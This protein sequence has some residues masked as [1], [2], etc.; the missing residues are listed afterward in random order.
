M[1]FGGDLATSREL[2]RQRVLAEFGTFALRH[3]AAPDLFGEA[4]RQIAHATQLGHV[5]IA[6]HEAGQDSFVAVAS[7]GVKSPRGESLR[8]AGAPNSA[9]ERVRRTGHSVLI[10]DTRQSGEAEPSDIARQ[11]GLGSV[12]TL[13][14]LQG[15][16]VTGV[17]EIG[18]TEPRSLDAADV[19]LVEAMAYMLGAALAR[20]EAEAERDTLL[21]VLR[22][23]E[24]RYRFMA[25]SIPHIVWTAD[26]KGRIDFCNSRWT[27]Y[28]GLPLEN[29]IGDNW[30]DAIHPEDREITVAGWRV[31][32]A[33]GTEFH[34]EHRIRRAGGDWRWMVSRA[35]PLRNEAGHV[36]RWFGTSTDIDIERQARQALLDARDAAE[37]ANRAKSR[38]LAAASHDLR[39]PLNAITL[40]VAVLRSRIEDDDMLELIDRIE[41]SLGAM[42]ELFEALLD[43]SKLESG[44]VQLNVRPVALG[45]VLE[46]IEQDFRPVAEA[47]GLRFRV[48]PTGLWIATD[49]T[50]LER[51]LRNLVSN[52]IRYTE[53]G[54][55]LV[56]ARARGD[57]VRVEVV[58][59][60]PG[61]P[62]EHQEEIFDE[63]R[64]LRNEA[65]ERGSGHG[66]GLA[67][68]KRASGLLRHPVELKSR[69]G[70]GSRFI[71]EIP[72]AAPETA[73]QENSP[74]LGTTVPSVRHLVLVIEDDSL[75]LTATRLLLEQYGS[76]VL[77]ARTAEEA[78]TIVR[79]GAMPSAVVADF[80]LPGGVDG[81]EA[82]RM[83]RDALGH[84]IPTVLVTGDVTDDVE[85]R[86]RA[87]GVQLLRKPVKP[88]D[89]TAILQPG[90]P[91]T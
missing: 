55:V 31:A 68:V 41:G 64:Q 45:S 67:I 20:M 10:P 80:R 62:P 59:T 85:P 91:G 65:R 79:N 63:F 46:R 60:G 37:R 5:V 11:A 23:K 81:L 40:L 34:V 84:E 57:R 33:T 12:A 47:K 32:V 78:L 35:W 3:T 25:E 19:Y 86:A 4:V 18:G 22:E 36:V 30:K 39:Q 88:D 66:L 50:L 9:A 13:P 90:R 27:E 52:A 56:G 53:R 70:R 61:I 48:L 6:L 82:I 26:S 49:S 1:R 77:A 89:L 15:G 7:V 8:L 17:I 21:T 38:F 87:M 29:A 2:T 24:R 14:I 44:A 69:L 76:G 58:D 28:T 54:G 75:V 73:G 16:V 42:I 74:G 71:V 43:L 72:R 83:L 51:M